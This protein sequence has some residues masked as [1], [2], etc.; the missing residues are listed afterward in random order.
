MQK[1]VEAA[2][3]LARKYPEQVVLVTT[4]SRKG[5]PNVMAVGWVAIASSDP[6]MFVLGIDDEALT[7]ENIRKTREEVF[8]K[9]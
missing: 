8:V 2:E 5:K 1:L 9:E 7:Y 4:R 6:W 3:A